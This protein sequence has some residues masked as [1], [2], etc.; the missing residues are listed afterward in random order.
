MKG[1]F[2]G[3]SEEKKHEKTLRR[4][5]D[6][7]NKI[8]YWWKRLWKGNLPGIL[9]SE[10]LVKRL[11]KKIGKENRKPP[12]IFFKK[13]NY[14]KRKQILKIGNVRKGREKY[15]RKDWRGK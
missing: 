9:I 3:N 14:Q 2:E 5:F 7:E 8:N 15:H 11:E 10:L 4:K 13:E 6:K 1:K 12:E